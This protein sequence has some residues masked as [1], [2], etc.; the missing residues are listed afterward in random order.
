MVS[1]VVWRLAKFA[2]MPLAVVLLGACG[3]GGGGDDSAQPSDPTPTDPAIQSVALAASWSNILGANRS[4]QLDKS[5]GGNGE[6]AFLNVS[7]QEDQIFAVDGVV[8]PASKVTQ[9]LYQW[10]NSS[11]VLREKTYIDISYD[12]VTKIPSGLVV[13]ETSRFADKELCVV[14]SANLALQ[15]EVAENTSGVLLSGRRSYTYEDEFRAGV[16]AGY[17]DTTSSNSVSNVSW[18]IVKLGAESRL[19]CVVGIPGYLTGDYVSDMC[20]E[21]SSSGV[22][23]SKVR[24][25]E[26][27]SVTGVVSKEFTNF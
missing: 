17:C 1:T 8:R 2:A 14:N 6:T 7:P 16:Y 18:S 24:V 25:K 26:Y 5:V 15:A 21:I 4:W 12:P 23:G 10:S 20:F 22:L 27:N 13:Y 9:V 11:G 3:G 19:F